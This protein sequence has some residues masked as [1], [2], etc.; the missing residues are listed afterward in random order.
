MNEKIVSKIM[1]NKN[2]NND[3]N[4]ESEEDFTG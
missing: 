2:I 4:S 3:E 1:N